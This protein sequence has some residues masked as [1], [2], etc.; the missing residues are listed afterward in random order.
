MIASQLL[1]RVTVKY[2]FS[3][4][5]V[6]RIVIG[7]SALDILVRKSCTEIYER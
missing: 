5:R 2:Q 7:S 1:G 6:S 3:V 4:S